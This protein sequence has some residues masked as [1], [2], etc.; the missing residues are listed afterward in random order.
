MH[1]VAGNF[2]LVA[3]PAGQERRLSEFRAVRPWPLHVFA[4]CNFSSKYKIMLKKK[5]KKEKEGVNLSGPLFQKRRNASGRA[6][7]AANICKPS[8]MTDWGQ[9]PVT[10]QGPPFPSQSLTTGTRRR[11]LLPADF[12]RN[13]KCTHLL[14]RQL[15]HARASLFPAFPV[16]RGFWVSVR[17]LFLPISA[18]LEGRASK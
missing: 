15:T 10:C 18:L 2:F 4:S 17:H 6:S 1:P 8:Q 9:R 3:A 14:P 13:D 11:S 12:E 5:K 16:S 7:D